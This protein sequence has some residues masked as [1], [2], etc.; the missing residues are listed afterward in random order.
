MRDY[1]AELVDVIATDSDLPFVKITS[2]ASLIGKAKVNALVQ[3]AVQLNDEYVGFFRQVQTIGSS[4][5]IVLLVT[6]LSI[7][8]GIP[9]FIAVVAV[10]VWCCVK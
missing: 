5:N 9:I 6:L 2:W 10:S 4:L 8:I 7:F 1:T 3:T